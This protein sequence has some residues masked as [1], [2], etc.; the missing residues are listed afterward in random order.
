[1]RLVSLSGRS[2]SYGVGKSNQDVQTGLM[3]K[4]VIMNFSM[5]FD[6]TRVEMVSINFG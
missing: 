4:I 5:L 6:G 3:Q 1:M 2:E